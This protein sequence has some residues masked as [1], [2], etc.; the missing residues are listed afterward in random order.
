MRTHRILAACCAL[1]LLAAAPLASCQESARPLYQLNARLLNQLKAV[2][3]EERFAA[4][5]ELH[6][7]G[8]AIIPLLIERSG[9]CE[10]VYV[11]L[12][13][14][15]VSTL[16][17]E[18]TGMNCSGIIYAYMVELILA[19][20]DLAKG[21]GGEI[22][23]PL[24]AD[25]HNYIYANGIILTGQDKAPSPKEMAAIQNIY[26]AWWQ[27]NQGKTIDELRQ[28]WKNRAAPLSGSPYHWK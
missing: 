26:L 11:G 12:M 9:E 3:S 16:H 25:H 7:Q 19:R 15:I 22:S 10:P 21:A 13:N 6:R 23:W 27:G 24:G 20:T 2:S 4:A 14:P 18:V 17:P 28:D 5:R 8:K 1:M